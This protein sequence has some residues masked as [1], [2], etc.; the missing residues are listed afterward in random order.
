[1]KKKLPNIAAIATYFSTKA[2]VLGFCFLLFA[3]TS[4]LAQQSITALSG[5]ASGSGGSMAYSVGQIVYTVQTGTNGSLSQGI[6]Q[7]YEIS[8]TR[9][10]VLGIGINLNL[11]VYPNPAINYVMLV[12]DNYDKTLSYQLYNINGQLL[13]NK[14][15]VTNSTTIKMEQYPAGIYFLNVNR[16]NKNVKIFKIIKN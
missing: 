6:Q 4:L 1:M 16:N 2:I 13:E 7:P 8:I 12:V 14:S 10:E 3:T 11:S 15:V 9:G 5:E